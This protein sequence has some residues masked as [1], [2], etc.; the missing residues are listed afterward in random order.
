MTVRAVLFDIDGT[1]VDSNDLHV[2]AWIEAFAA[3]GLTT[4]AEAIHAQIGKG[5]D[6]LVPALVPGA[7]TELADSAIPLRP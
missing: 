6:L 1:L 4:T 7:D 2:R 5:A 3:R